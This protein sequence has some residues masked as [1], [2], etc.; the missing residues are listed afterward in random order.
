MNKKMKAK[1]TITRDDLE[2]KIRELAIKKER[3][4]GY[5]E[6][7]EKWQLEGKEFHL[8][9]CKPEYDGISGIPPKWVPGKLKELF[10]DARMSIFENTIDLLNKPHDPYEI[11]FIIDNHEQVQKLHKN[12]PFE[13]YSSPGS[14][15]D[16]NIFERDFKFIYWLWG[17][18]QKGPE[19][20]LKEMAGNFAA[21][22]WE[23]QKR[24]IIEIVNPQVKAASDKHKEWRRKAEK[25][26]SKNERLSISDVAKK[27]DPTR[28][29][30]IR[31]VISDLKPKK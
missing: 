1:L 14:V 21:T 30:T 5:F 20:S 19:I 6:L 2:A 8:D 22:Q 24:F 7:V 25:T 16:A 23:R 18:V 11:K 12:S 27:I 9:L 15:K 3:G 28:Y 13:H 31:G 17:A 4:D 29:N 10:F 26:W